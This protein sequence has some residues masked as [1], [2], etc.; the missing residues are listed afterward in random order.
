MTENS[1]VFEPFEPLRYVPFSQ[2]ILPPLIPK[3]VPTKP[4]KGSYGEGREA[5]V[6][7]DELG[8]F[9]YAT[10][11]AWKAI[12]DYFG[13]NLRLREL[14]GIV[15]GLIHHIQNLSGVEL[16][17]PSRNAKRNLPLLVKYVNTHYAELAPFFRCV[18][19]YDEDWQAIPF[20]DATIELTQN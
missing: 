9:D 1:I 7:R 17:M 15:F 11:V 18:R 5:Q 3:P 2:V 4:P 19:L 10:S 16:P 12:T 13:V 8:D 14:K 6:V 20:L